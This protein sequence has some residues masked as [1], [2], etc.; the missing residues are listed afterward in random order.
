VHSRFTFENAVGQIS[1]FCKIRN[2]IRTKSRAL[3]LSV[4]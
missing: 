2:L 1:I 4:N 3:K